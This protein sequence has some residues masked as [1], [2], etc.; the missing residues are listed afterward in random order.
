MDKDGTWV[1]QTSSLSLCVLGVCFFVC[2]ILCFHVNCNELYA[3][4][5]ETAHKRAQYDGDDC[6]FCS[7]HLGYSQLTR[8][9][10]AAPPHRSLRAVPAFVWHVPL[11]LPQLPAP[12]LRQEGEPHGLQ[13][14]HRC[15][16][17]ELGPVF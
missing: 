4:V 7:A 9:L 6:Y 3:L 10:H 5:G 16:R 1:S 2:F 13:R 15:K 14:R 8:H 12:P 11:H 17:D